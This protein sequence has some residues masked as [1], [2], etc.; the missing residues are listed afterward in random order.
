MRGIESKR[1]NQNQNRETFA[2]TTK[3]NTKKNFY[4]CGLPLH[5][6]YTKTKQERKKNYKRIKI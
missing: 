3:R 2:N 5:L 4:N 6:K 1:Q